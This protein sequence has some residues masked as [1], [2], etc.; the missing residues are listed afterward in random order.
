M[1]P[2]KPMKIDRNIIFTKLEVNKLAVICGTVSI[3]NNITIPTSLIEST[4]VIAIKAIIV[5]FIRLTGIFRVFAK[6]ES[7]AVYNISR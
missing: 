6:S 2:I 5:Y 1:Q 3:D 7:N 4:M